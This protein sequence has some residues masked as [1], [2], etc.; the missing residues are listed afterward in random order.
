M[1]RAQR[2]IDDVERLLASLEALGDRRKQYSVL[3]VG[4]VKERADVALRV[5]HRARESNRLVMD[6]IHGSSFHVKDTSCDSAVVVVKGVSQP[7]S[8]TGTESWPSSPCPRD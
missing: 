3:F 8:V 1:R 6:G 5:K 7:T 4:A 2:G